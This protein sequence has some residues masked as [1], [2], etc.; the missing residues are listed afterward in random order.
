MAQST[1]KTLKQL[2]I[3]QM[4]RSVYNAKKAAGELDLEQVY[5]PDAVYDDS[6]GLTSATPGQIIKVKAVDGD[7]KP[8]EW[9]A[10]DMPGGGGGDWAELPII[11]TMQ[12]AEAVNALAI[13]DFTISRRGFVVV[14][15]PKA[16]G[17]AA[18]SRVDVYVNGDSAMDRCAYYKS[19][20]IFSSINRV[21]YLYIWRNPDGS[22]ACAGEA[23]E[24]GKYTNNTADLLSNGGQ[25]VSPYY[26][27]AA[28]IQ[29][30]RFVANKNDVNFP[31][32]TV[33]T[34]RGE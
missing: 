19:Y 9:E 32:G 17:T 14:D 29:S 8:T 5:L 6:L 26:M 16:D 15:M 24:K 2:I 27:G 31:A 12:S 1:D 34:I 30:L 28:A 25:A 18:Y 10:V 7:G 11:K 4:P 3:N 22:Y 21:L 33:V 20:G 23:S 13:S